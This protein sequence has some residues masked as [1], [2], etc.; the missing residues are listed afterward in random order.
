MVLKGIVP[1]FL[2]RGECQLERPFIGY[3]HN[4]EVN[5]MA[6]RLHIAAVVLARQSHVLRAHT[7][8]QVIGILL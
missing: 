7:L 5:G 6:R 2:V 1:Q 4:D 3:E 8:H